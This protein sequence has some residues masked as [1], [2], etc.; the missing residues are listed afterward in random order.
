MLQSNACL[1][2]IVLYLT[3]FTWT[4]DNCKY[5]WKAYFMPK[6]IVKQKLIKHKIE[7][8][9]NNPNLST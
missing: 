8:V 2:M 6:I 7:K 5:F 3:K 1:K 4:V 9:N